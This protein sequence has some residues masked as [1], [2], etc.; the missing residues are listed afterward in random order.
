MKRRAS[1]KTLEESAAAECSGEAISERDSVIS[2]YIEWLTLGIESIEELLDRMQKDGLTRVSIS[3]F[4]PSLENLKREW[5]TSWIEDIEDRHRATAKFLDEYRSLSFR[6]YC[7]LGKLTREIQ[8]CLPDSQQAQQLA[9]AIGR[10]CEEVYGAIQCGETRYASG[11]GKPQPEDLLSDVRHG[12]L[13]DNVENAIVALS[14]AQA[15]K[16]L[17]EVGLRKIL[18]E[19]LTNNSDAKKTKQNQRERAAKWLKNE[20]A[21]GRKASVV[22]AARQYGNELASEKINGGYKDTDSLLTGLNKYAKK[23]GIEQF[24]HRRKS[25]RKR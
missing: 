18:K 4:R 11:N 5:F 23:L 14:A 3:D 12:A 7:S 6:Y 9:A 21:A 10:L 16:P 15:E 22:D 20:H 1:K 17:S 2:L 24:I 13:W 19:Q 25:R 8:D